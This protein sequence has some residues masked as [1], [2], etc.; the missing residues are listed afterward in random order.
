MKV[1]IRVGEVEVH[2]DGLDLS[3]RDVLKMLGEIAGV[4]LAVFAT[5]EEPAAS[6]PIGF[7]A[8]VERAPDP[9]IDLS[10]YFEDE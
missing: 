2:T 9:E 10:E 7:T 8:Q 5:E 1:R 6:N 3:K 4:S